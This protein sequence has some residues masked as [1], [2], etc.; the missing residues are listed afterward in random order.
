M[1]SEVRLSLPDATRT[2]QGDNITLVQGNVDILEQPST[3][4]LLFGEA[5]SFKERH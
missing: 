2:G 1:D 5:A 3:I 4:R